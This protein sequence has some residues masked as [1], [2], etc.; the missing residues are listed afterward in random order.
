MSSFRE[1][2]L[3]GLKKLKEFAKICEENGIQYY[4]SWGTLLGAV[5]HKG[6]I[7]WDNDIDIS[8]PIADYRRFIRLAPKKLPSWLFLQTYQTDR[9]Y[10]ELWAKIRANGTTSLPLIWKDYN[11][12]RGIGIDVFPIVGDAGSERGIKLQQKAF[13]LSRTLLA[14]E[15]LVAIKS[16]ELNNK[17]LRILYAIP[18]RIRILMC[19]ILERIAFRKM[20]PDRGVALAGAR[21]RNH[22]P[23]EAFGSGGK[24]VFE[25]CEFEAPV[26]WDRVLTMMFGDYMTPPPPEKRGYGHELIFGKIIYDC[27]KDYREYLRNTSVNE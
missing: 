5:R 19:R 16:P 13:H 10:N 3:Y 12:H 23:Y 18:W 22:Y 6:F 2:Q 4:L 26:D 9:G 17:K 7:P 27:D 21:L 14:K 25:D 11:I 8:M 20:R 15:Y 24:A 1:I